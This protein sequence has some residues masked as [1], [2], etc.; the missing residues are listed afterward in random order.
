MPHDRRTRRTS[1]IMIGLVCSAIPIGCMKPSNLRPEGTPLPDLAP[2]GA[3]QA[4]ASTV[5]APTPEPAPAPEPQPVPAL[6]PLGP[7]V[8]PPPATRAA[9]AIPN[10]A[11][12][13]VLQAGAAT[14]IQA[15][16]AIP[17]PSATTTP[18]LPSTAPAIVP[19]PTPAR[20]QPVAPPKPETP[21]AS[22][23]LL[24]AEIRRV[25]DLTQRHFDA[26][27]ANDASESPVQSSGIRPILDLEAVKSTEPSSEAGPAPTSTPKPATPDS[28]ETL[29][30]PGRLPILFAAETA[31]EEQSPG[32]ITPAPATDGGKIA[33]MTE[34]T[35]REPADDAGPDPSKA[36]ERDGKPDQ[37]T[38]RVADPPRP[39]ED[40]QASAPATQERPRPGIAELRLCGQIHRFGE[41]EPLDSTALKAG[42]PVLVYCELTDLEYE[43]RSDDFVS[44]LASHVELRPESGGAIVWE[45]SLPTA[46]D[47]C[48]RRRHDYFV[49]YRI[50]LPRSL[51]PGSY[52]LRLIQ[53]DLVAG[54]TTSAEIPM[55]IVP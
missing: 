10:A 2:A 41:F 26:L 9:G 50:Y 37:S 22:T 32:S 28:A 31:P 20:V 17:N 5:A 3:P 52:R 51:E 45:Q 42:Q 24:D 11:D 29:E 7:L 16:A 48:H 25:E 8:Q 6:P 36:G 15:G 23:P 43:T 13:T 35:G 14:P 39:D 1:L 19:Q 46:V 30:E 33:P 49:S 44:R 18:N 53:T 12:P 34:A 27:H 54:R 4:G 38:E 47:V 40:D 55:T 21:P